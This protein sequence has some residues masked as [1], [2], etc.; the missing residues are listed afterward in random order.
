MRRGS[1]GGARSQ[2]RTHGDYELRFL[3]AADAGGG[4]SGAG[5]AAGPAG[6]GPALRVE[7]VGA[8]ELQRA[9]RRARGER[10]DGAIGAG[11]GRTRVKV[12]V[13]R[14]LGIESSCD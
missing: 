12:L 1:G 13:V 3:Y 9:A 6:G 14:I 10:A 5:A 7:S 2:Q 4:T 8:V 11:G